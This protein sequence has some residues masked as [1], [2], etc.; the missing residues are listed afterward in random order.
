MPTLILFS[1]S[2]NA[3]T[4]CSYCDCWSLFIQAAVFCLVM[5]TMAEI[6]KGNDDR[7]QPAPPRMSSVLRQFIFVLLGVMVYLVLLAV[8]P[9][10]VPPSVLQPNPRV[11]GPPSLTWL[12]RVA[13]FIRTPYVQVFAFLIFLFQAV[14]RRDRH[15]SWIYAFLVGFSFPSILFHWVLHWF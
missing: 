1:H 13:E 12:F 6:E 15:N 14:Y 3:E 9:R 8:T 5:G 11:E 7:Q 10:P 2:G 4:N